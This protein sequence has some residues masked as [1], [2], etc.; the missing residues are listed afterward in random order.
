MEARSEPPEG[1]K[2]V[3]HVIINRKK[4]GRW[5]ANYA[6]VCLAALQFSC[7]NTVDPNRAQMARVPDDDAILSKCRDVLTEAESGGDPTD[8]ATHYF[9]ASIKPPWWAK[10]A[11]FCGRFGSQLFYKNVK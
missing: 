6:S 9:A 11:F 2:A 7:W 4:L 3:A 10:Q 1:Q 5:G 8:G